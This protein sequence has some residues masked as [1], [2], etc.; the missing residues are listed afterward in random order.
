MKITE[1]WLKNNDACS[2]G[3]EWWKSQGSPETAAEIIK[4]AINTDELDY[5]Y[6]IIEHTFNKRQ[7]VTLAKFAA[8]AA[9]AAVDAAYDA[10]AAAY[11]ADAAADAARAADAVYAAVYGDR[12]A[13]AARAM[14]VT[15]LNKA[16]E[17]IEA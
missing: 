13:D 6:W 11:A 7:S 16:I 5:A 4:A 17:L 10:Y 15:I 12:A 9:D 1:K 8:D 2:D 3:V 14:Q